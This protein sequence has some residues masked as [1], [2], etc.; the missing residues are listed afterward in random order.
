MAL[1]DAAWEARCSAI[2]DYRKKS[3]ELANQREESLETAC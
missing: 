2:G 1:L 3:L